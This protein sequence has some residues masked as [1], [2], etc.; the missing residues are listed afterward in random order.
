[1]PVILDKVKK[2]FG[3]KHVFNSLS[4]TFPDTGII[5]IMGPSGCGKTTLLRMIAALDSP[6]SGEIYVQNK[7]ISFLFQEPRLFNWLTA[8]ENVTVI[9]SPHADDCVKRAVSILSKIGLKDDMNKYPHELSGGM[10][11]RISLARSLAFGGDIYL[12]DEPFTGLD[13]KLKD[14][15]SELI[16]DCCKSSLCIIVTHNINDALKISDSII[17]FT[18][19]ID[20][21]RF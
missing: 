15:V 9:G 6:D 1:M 7:K 13:P 14:S 8:I 18:N 2:S 11:R 21:Y 5:S 3:E 17:T 4:L 20:E 12:M 19:T 16:K 10:K